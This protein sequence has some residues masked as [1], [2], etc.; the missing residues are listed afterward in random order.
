[1][2]PLLEAAL[3]APRYAREDAYL[4]AVTVV[5][6]LPTSTTNMTGLRT[7]QRGFS[8]INDSRMARW[9]SSR[10]TGVCFLSWVVIATPILLAAKDQEMLDNGTKP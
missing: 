8:L 7:I 4:S 10:R 5:S 3:Q 9:Y 2:Y 1:M 6:T